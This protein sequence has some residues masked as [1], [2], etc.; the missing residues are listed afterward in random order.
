MRSWGLGAINAQAAFSTGASGQGILIAD[1]DTGADPTRPDLAGAISPLSTN[2]VPAGEPQALQGSVVGFDPHANDV[3]SVLAARFNGFGTIGVAY[4]STVLSIRADSCINGTAANNC[5]TASPTDTA[6]L[7]KNFGF[8]DLDLANGIE[9]AIQNHARVINLSLGSPS[10]SSPAVQQAL[11]DATNAGIAVTIS[12][13]NDSK[14]GA[15][16]PNPE[17]PAQLASQAQYGGL[18]VAV[19]ASTQPGT[20]IAVF[21]NQAGNTANN[22]LVAPGDQIVA[23]CD[24]SETCDVVSG[25]SFS[26]P[27]V[28]GAIALL[29]QAFPNLTAAQAVNILLTTADPGGAGGVNSVYGRGILDLTK[30]FQPIGAMSIPTPSGVAIVVNTGAPVSGTPGVIT[31]HALGDAVQNSR[32]LSTIGYDSYHR[33]F[34]I[35]LNGAYAAPQAR[36]LI[37][38]APAQRQFGADYAVGN[39]ARLSFASSAPLVSAPDAVEGLGFSQAADPS[40][41][42]VETG[43][44]RL[45]LTAWRGQGGAQPDLGEPRDAFEAV[46]APN[47]VES[48]KINLGALSLVAE[49]G[50]GEQTPPYGNHPLK[51]SSYERIGADFAGRGF[52]ARVA[53]GALDEPL[54]PLG[55]TITGAFALPSRT[56]FL[57]I[58]VD[59]GLAGG[60]LLY[61]EA[62]LGRTGFNGQLLQLRDST[63]SSWRLGLASPCRRWRGCSH[64]GFEVDQPLRFESGEIT[65]NLAAVPQAYFAP[66]EFTTRRIG[67]APSGRELDF[68][69]F[70]DRDLGAFGLVSLEGTAA[71]QEGNIAGAPVGL[72]LL[73]S[74]RVGF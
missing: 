42:M 71:S 56:Q 25:T 62:S 4:N 55:S 31:T 63:T 48:A 60:A 38:A 6:A 69:L 50:T 24:M 17:F 10:P 73:A 70:A 28:A 22:F 45:A 68:R 74:W 20:T 35:N 33:L 30:A 66:L 47:Q 37:A 15:P 23:N 8:N 41:A 59:K 21:S 72:G 40:F 2:V 9:Y 3:S 36:G 53:A 29:L 14:A 11:L 49:G 61:G 67:A 5:N 1:V 13:G 39:G 19:G 52:T 34:K 44:G 64:L 32:S 16:A 46:A 7:L 12:A 51:A 58:G 26:S 54:G 57:T 27:H 65:A 43:V 18:I